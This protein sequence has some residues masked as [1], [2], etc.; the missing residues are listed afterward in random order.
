MQ[1]GDLNSAQGM[2]VLRDV[3]MERHLKEVWPTAAYLKMVAPDNASRSFELVDVCLGVPSTPGGG[4][5]TLQGRAYRA[6]P[7]ENGED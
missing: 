4:R 5:K 6:L 7:P 2:I 1:G 3:E